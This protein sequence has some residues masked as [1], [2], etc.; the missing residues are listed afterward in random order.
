MIMYALFMFLFLASG[1]AQAQTDFR[2]DVLRSKTLKDEPGQL[3]ITTSGIEYRSVNGKTSIRIPF[4]NIRQMDI[5]DPSAIRIETY[6]M[7][8]RKLSGRQTYMFRLHSPRSIR[9]NENL[10]RFLS[11]KVSRPVLASYST[12]DEPEFEIP[13]YHRHVL[14]G[15]N[16][17]IQITPEGIRFLSELEPHSRTWLYSEI[18]T[19]GGADPFSFRVT[20]LTETY[21]FDLKQPLPRQAY[22]IVWQRVYDLQQ[23]STAEP[24]AVPDRRP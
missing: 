9:E 1:T 20:T 7:L 22:D 3:Q 4:L 24:P 8:K 12:A 13:A 18:K 11:D 5:S 6:E 21:T 15:C 16:G 17:T 14:S 10:V 2:Y 19:V 23:Y